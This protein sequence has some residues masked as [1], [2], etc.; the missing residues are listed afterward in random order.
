MSDKEPA[1]H[2]EII[3]S[4]SG[5]TIV[6]GGAVEIYRVHFVRTALGVFAKGFPGDFN[7]LSFS[8]ALKLAGEMTGKKYR[9]ADAEAARDDLNELIKTTIAAARHSYDT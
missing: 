5:R 8:R 4:K 6:T 3:H 7:G 9:R 1:D 2:G